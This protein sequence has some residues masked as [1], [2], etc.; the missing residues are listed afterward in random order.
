MRILLGNAFYLHPFPP[1][2][3]N[4]PSNKGHETLATLYEDLRREC[5]S[6]PH[7]LTLRDADRLSR[8]LG[9]K[10]VRLAQDIKQKGRWQMV[11][12]IYRTADSK[13][14]EPFTES[15]LAFTITC[16]RV[17]HLLVGSEN[18]FL[19]G[20][21]NNRSAWQHWQAPV[22]SSIWELLHAFPI[23]SDIEYI[24]EDD[25]DILPPADKWK[26]TPQEL[27]KIVVIP[28]VWRQIGDLLEHAYYNQQYMPHPKG[29]L[30]RVTGVE[31]LSHL[32]I[33]VKPGLYDP[34]Y[35]DLIGVFDYGS[36]KEVL[37]LS[38]ITGLSRVIEPLQRR[39]S[40]DRQDFLYWLMV[41]V[42]HDLVTARETEGRSERRSQRIADSEAFEEETNA[43]PDITWTPI[44]RIIK[45]RSTEP[46]QPLEHPR[47]LIPHRVRGYRRKGEMTEKHRAV[48]EELERTTGLQILRWIKPGCTFVRPHIS[49]AIEPEEIMRLPLFIRAKIE[50]EIRRLFEVD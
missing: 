15:H 28:N 46:R 43:G 13:R 5:Y 38:G 1:V 40:E 35:I 24:D 34:N 20:V 33:K 8:Y 22:R 32:T 17:I 4:L 39:S 49:P 2:I 26:H 11:A 6:I 23:D 30:V 47:N 36:T 44:P 21:R 10:L 12:D 18:R 7:A 37:V 16:G 29:S 27:P 25:L 42:Y 41:Q 50:Q 19:V 31:G 45:S 9:R 3:P 48:L 14:L